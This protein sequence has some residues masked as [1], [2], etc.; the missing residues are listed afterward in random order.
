MMLV[1]TIFQT[2]FAAFVGVALH[3]GAHYA[4]A[5]AH[6][7]EARIDVRDVSTVVEPGTV[8]EGWEIAAFAL[9]PLVS[10]LLF[11]PIVLTQLSIPLVAG[12]LFYTLGGVRNDVRLAV[13]QAP[14]PGSTPE[15]AVSGRGD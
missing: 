8:V 2:V 7:W 13:G 9:A 1:A 11:T 4:V 12:W 14:D 15:A 6:G 10:G 3:E 5:W